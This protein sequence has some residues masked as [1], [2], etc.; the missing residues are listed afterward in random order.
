MQNY[1]G[2]N[3]E[4]I[5]LANDHGG[6]LQFRGRIFSECSYYDEESNSITR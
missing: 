1:S 4:Q 6:E 2:D 3:M 5:V